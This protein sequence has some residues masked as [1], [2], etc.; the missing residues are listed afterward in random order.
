MIMPPAPPE[1]TAAPSRTV[2]AVFPRA[3]D[4][5]HTTSGNPVECTSG[6]QRAPPVA[7]GR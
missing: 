2:A 4:Y 5:V 1:T 6:H 3:A 7:A